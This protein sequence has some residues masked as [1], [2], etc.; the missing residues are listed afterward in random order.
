M[1]LCKC[2]CGLECKRNYVLGHNPTTEEARLKIS[3]KLKGKA[4]RIWTD[5]ERKLWCGEKNPAFG[6]HWE[7]KNRKPK[8]LLEKE[9]KN[10]IRESVLKLWKNPEF[11]KK[12]RFCGLDGRF[13]NTKPEKEMKRCLQELGILYVFQYFVDSI[14]HRYYADFYLPLY[15][16]II[17]VDGYN[18][19]SSQDE[20]EKD[21]TRMKEMEEAGYRVLRFQDKEFDA[22]SVWREI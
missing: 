22:Q 20:L 15:G 13:F 10:K 18:N 16:I 11:L 3:Q 4:S 5:K 7:V 9:H 19:H 17:E 2:G 14:K 8:I 12:R 1:N 21:I 6:K